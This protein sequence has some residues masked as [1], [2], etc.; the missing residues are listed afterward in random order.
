MAEVDTAFLEGSIAIGNNQP[1]KVFQQAIPQFEIKYP[2]WSNNMRQLLMIK[3][4]S[5]NGE[6]Y[7][8][9]MMEHNGLRNITTREIDPFYL[10]CDHSKFITTHNGSK[11]CSICGWFMMKTQSDQNLLEQ[12]CNHPFQYCILN[13]SKQLQ[14]C[15]KCGKIM[16][17]H[18][19]INNL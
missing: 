9:Y 8:K 3:Q 10:L 7:M 5:P 4:Q 13:Y 11:I 12:K 19:N 17:Y 2:F 14:R 1:P 18:C 16:K 6:Q 15:G